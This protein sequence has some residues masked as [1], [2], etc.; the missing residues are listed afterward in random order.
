MEPEIVLG[1]GFLRFLYG[2]PFGRFL[3]NSLFKRLFFSRLF[4][5]IQ[6]RRFSRWKIEK[7][8]ARLNID[9]SE[10]EKGPGEF[11][12]FNDFF[13][14][15]LKRGARPVDEDP[16]TV[17]SPCDARMLACPRIERGARISVKGNEFDAADLLDDG[18][19]ASRYEGGALLIY[20]LCPADYHRFHFPEACL[21]GSPTMIM[22]HLHSVNPIALQS[23]IPILD[24]NLRHRTLLD[25][26]E[27]AGSI[28]MVEIGAM[29]V[30][31]VVQ[32]H[33]PDVSVE[34][35]DEK[36]MFR[37]GGSTV[38]VL[39]EAGRIHVDEDILQ[40]SREG[41]ET[42]VKLGTRVGSYG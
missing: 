8:A 21:P 5:R 27:R 2:N 33:K 36:G 28:A 7:V 15:A 18:E 16:S 12:N 4:G 23:G 31:S 29:C 13:T 22:G 35:G 41:V 40:H 17:I 38:I 42:Y 20:R 26:G 24:T 10:A 3:G 9:L 25:A 11:E 14:R 39:Y 34:R 19:I 30:G 32:T 6:D 1:E 37:F